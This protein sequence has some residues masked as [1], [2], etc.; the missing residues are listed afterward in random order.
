MHQEMSKQ[1]VGVVW[2]QQASI[3]TMKTGFDNAERKADTIN[4]DV[5]NLHVKMDRVMST[6]H[7]QGRKL[8]ELEK[9]MVE[10][11]QKCN[12]M[13]QWNIRAIERQDNVSIYKIEQQLSNLVGDMEELKTHVS[14]ILI[15]IDQMQVGR[16]S[17]PSADS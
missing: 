12:N 14:N 11:H 13:T 5:K 7:T 3:D 10:F 6:V 16:V 4:I 15:K 9:S 1:N 8:E 2:Q 17:E